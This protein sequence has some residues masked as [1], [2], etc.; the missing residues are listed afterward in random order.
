MSDDAN[1]HL[2]DDERPSAYLGVV[3]ENIEGRLKKLEEPKIK[4]TIEKIKDNASF[5]ALLIGI[6]LSVLSLGNQ[7]WSQPHQEL[8]R[9]IVEFNKT[10]NEVASLRQSIVS[11]FQTAKDPQSAQIATQMVTPQIIAD[12]QYASSL[13][14]RIGDHAG[15]AQLVILTNEAIN[16]HDWKSAMQMIDAATSKTDQPPTVLSE[17]Y[18]YKGRVLF[19]T[20]DFI[21]GAAA[22][23]KALTLIQDDK[24]AGTDG[25]RAMIALDWTF[26]AMMANRCD[27]ANAVGRRAAAFVSSNQ[28]S[29]MQRS[30]L[31]GLL[32]SSIGQLGT[33]TSCSIP[34]SLQVI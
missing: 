13:L 3:I 16:L 20:D 14:K 1:S 15:V 31:L 34:E 28:V 2:D 7:L 21:G 8:E 9:D 30:A 12:I 11:A 32:R 10:S 22:F 19:L 26:F 25:N 6:V 4:T 24:S 18:R 17:A 27:E 23:E 5:L 33:G 29:Q